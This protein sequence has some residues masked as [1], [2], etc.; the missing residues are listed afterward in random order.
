MK[1]SSRMIQICAAMHNF[2]RRQE[3]LDLYYEYLSE[4]TLALY[5]EDYIFVD[6]CEQMPT[7]ERF[8]R[9]YFS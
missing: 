4:E 7:N 9:K 5:N 2:V 6:D 1:K 8:F 3:P